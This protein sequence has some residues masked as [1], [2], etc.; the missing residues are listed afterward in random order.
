M[1]SIQPNIFIAETASLSYSELACSFSLLIQSEQ[2][3]PLNAAK[4]P[5]VRV[6]TLLQC[7]LIYP[8]FITPSDVTSDWL[9]TD[10]P[11]ALICIAYPKGN[12]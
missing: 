5:K 11:G 7:L 9:Y 3:P 8:N 4:I 12:W 10:P 2:I 6:G 1:P